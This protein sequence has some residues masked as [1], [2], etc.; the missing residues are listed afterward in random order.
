MDGTDNCSA[1]LAVRIVW[2]DVVRW[3][4]MFAVVC[5]H[6]TDP[7]N[8]YSGA[9]PEIKD[10]KFWGAVYGAVLRPCVP[11][12]VMITG[13]LLL[14]VKGNASVFTGNA[15][16]VCCFRF[17]SGRCFITFSHG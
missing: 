7:F 16:L 2:L 14:P 4:A 13:A 9:S 15:Y 17:L 12:F 1:R 11:L 8:F 6:C 3:V 10:I 5:C